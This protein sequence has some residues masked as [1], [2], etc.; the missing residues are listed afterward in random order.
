MVTFKKGGLFERLVVVY[1]C[2]PKHKL[3]NYC[4][5]VK[6]AFLGLVY[7]ALG[8]LLFVYAVMVDICIALYFD[9]SILFDWAFNGVDDKIG[10]VDF[11]LFSIQAVITSII[12]IVQ[13]AAVLTVISSIFFWILD[14]VYPYLKEKLELYVLKPKHPS[15]YNTRKTIAL[16]IESYFSPARAI[17]NNIKELYSSI[18]DKYC[19]TVT[20]IEE[21][22]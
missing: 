8:I 7:I 2:C 3:T 9:T 11:L 6:H 20:W 17:G 15:K 16:A 12:I 19:P 14:E 13:C 5:L 10:I 21:E 18:K 22:K 1:G 4:D